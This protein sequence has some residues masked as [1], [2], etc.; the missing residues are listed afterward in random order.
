MNQKNRQQPICSRSQTTHTSTRARDFVE[1]GKKEKKKKKHAA[2]ERGES[3]LRAA[4][5]AP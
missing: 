3:N 1:A 5:Q 4:A 2:W